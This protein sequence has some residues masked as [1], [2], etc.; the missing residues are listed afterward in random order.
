MLQKLETT[1][2][3]KD[4]PQELAQQ[5]AEFYGTDF[6]HDRLKAQLTTLHC[7][8][9]KAINDLQSVVS[10]LKGLSEIEKEY[11]SEVI[12]VAK[13][14]LVMPATNALSERSFSA[15]RRIKTWLR[16]STS[17]VRLNNCMLLHVHK[18]K[19]DSLPLL[20]IGNEFIQRNS[21]R[22]HIFGQY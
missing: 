22:L 3:E 11:Y 2:I 1:L 17:Q 13:M 20:Q 6:D 5:I 15:L 19:T 21:S 9:S 10:Y 16:T 14:I 12:K 7:N 8:D 4:P 18:T